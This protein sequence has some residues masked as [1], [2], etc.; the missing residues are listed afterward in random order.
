MPFLRERSGRW[1]PVKIVAFAAT[2]LPALWIVVQGLTGDLGPRPMTEAIH[3][4][5]DWALRLLWITLA[6]TPAQRIFNFPRI[7]LAR[8]TLG[9]ATAAYAGLHISMYVADQHFDLL[10]VASEI[11]LR[12]YLLIGFFALAGLIALAATSS[13]AA[14]R[15]LGSRWNSL[16]RLVYG[17]AVLASVHFF[18]QSKLD[19]YQPVMMAGFLMWLLGL[20][21]LFRLNG[22]VTPL[23]L[24][25]LA[26]AAAV[27]T[28]TGEATIYMLTSGVDAH[29]ILLA[30]FD[31]DMEVRPAWWVLAA[32]LAVAVAGSWRYKPGR[33]RTRPR[34]I[35]SPVALPRATQVQ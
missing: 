2:L 23:H 1:S 26:A 13:D 22:E 5:G 25:F 35:A 17:I 10:K 29:R 3:Q 31:I 9:V 33:A 32:G 34:A 11:V 16:H 8:R 4:L 28:A 20:R 6:I 21:V 12:I 27:A 7:I 15:R 18:M 30:H 24:F 14:V 19:L